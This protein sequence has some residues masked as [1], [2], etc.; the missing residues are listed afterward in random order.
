[1]RPIADWWWMLVGFPFLI[2]VGIAMLIHWS[3]RFFQWLLRR[4]LLRCEACGALVDSFDEV[5]A[6]RRSSCPEKGAGDF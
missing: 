5:E 2:L 1:M 6:H 4:G 3:D